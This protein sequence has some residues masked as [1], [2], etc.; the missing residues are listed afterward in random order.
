MNTS[1]R[2]GDKL[3]GWLVRVW[4]WF[5]TL[6]F[7]QAWLVGRD[8][9][10][11]VVAVL[12]DEPHKKLVE[13]LR[14]L[15]IPGAQA[16]GI[17]LGTLTGQT[18]LPIKSNSAQIIADII[19]DPSNYTAGIRKAFEENPPLDFA[20]IE[21]GKVI[22]D[23]CLKPITSLLDAE[24]RNPDEA[25]YLIE[26]R[27]VGI[28]AGV[29]AFG[30]LAEI[31]GVGQ[32]QTVAMMLNKIV[33]GLA[34][35]EI[36][37]A[38]LE[39]LMSNGY[40]AVTTRFYNRRFRPHRWSASDL[41]ALYAEREITEGEFLDQMAE[42]GYRNEDAIKALRISEKD[43]T[44]SQAMQGYNLNIL[45]KG[46]VSRYLFDRGYNPDD[47]SYLIQ[48]EDE[49]KRQNDLNSISAIALTAFKK[50][51]L[52][53]NE[54]R[55]MRTAARVPRERI[56]IEVQLARLQLQTEKSDVTVSNVKGAYMNNVIARKEAD[57]YL[58]SIGI[59][60]TARQLL[61][62]TW[63]EEKAPK[64]LRLNSGTILA[65]YSTGVLDRNQTID[66]LKAIGWSGGDAE[67][68]VRVYDQRVTEKPRSLSESAVL[69]AYHNGI[70]TQSEATARLLE[71]NYTPE[72][73]GLI[74]QLA[75]LKP[76]TAAKHLTETHI[77]KLFQLGIF[78][79]VDAI[80]ELVAIGYDEDTAQLVLIAQTTKVPKAAT[81]TQ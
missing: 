77:V 26:G 66:K 55:Q 52:S 59:D 53:E 9:V 11:K 3:L 79:V 41:T 65:A 39:P 2:L 67:L 73:A 56:D 22:V 17:I 74:L 31:V 13:T 80:N 25:L 43:I 20:A 10:M 70:L 48:L 30:V 29:N 12:P 63:Q 19:K 36:S 71:L 51:L 5:S 16:F 57:N 40:R 1:T 45:D 64:V 14:T 15:P 47:I 27:I 8:K 44:V 7:I 23:T 72:D 6:P 24:E 61:L 50:G 54:Y 42:L 32:I 76:I 75:D 35:N 28:I 4:E 37:N 60:A 81:L 33:D 38:I 18:A 21:I 69:T 68:Q 49:Q 34:L 78:G 62:D 58:I 46:G